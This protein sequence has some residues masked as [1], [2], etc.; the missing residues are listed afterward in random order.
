MS[1]QAYYKTSKKQEKE[2]IQEDLLIEQVKQ[3]RRDHPHMGGR[4]LYIKLQPFMEA[5]AI[6]MGRDRLFDLLA[7]ANLLIRKRKRRVQTRP[8]LASF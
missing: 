6:K 2:T 1:R 3:I 4:K 5:N 7:A 8:V